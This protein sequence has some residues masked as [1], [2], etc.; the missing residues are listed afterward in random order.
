HAALDFGDVFR[1]HLTHH[2]ESAIDYVGTVFARRLCQY[3]RDHRLKKLFCAV[4]ENVI[5]RLEA[6]GTGFGIV[7]WRFRIAEA[8]CGHAAAMLPTEF[9]ED[10]S[11]DGYA[12]KRGAADVGIVEDAREIRGVLLHCG[13]T[14]ADGGFAVSAKIGKDQAI[15]CGQRF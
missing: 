7:S 6:S 3:A 5:R 8:E 4:L 14:F 13:G 2:A 10:V 12:D 1:G 9:E 15:A 11:A